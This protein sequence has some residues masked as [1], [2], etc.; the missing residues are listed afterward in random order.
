MSLAGDLVRGAGYLAVGW[1]LVRMP[2]IRVWVIAPILVGF[3]VYAGAAAYLLPLGWQW[4]QNAVAG[5]PEWFH[6]WLGFLVPLLGLVLGTLAVLLLGWL[7]VL[8]TMALASPFYGVLAARAEARLTGRRSGVERGLAHEALAAI[9]REGVKMAWYLPR[10]LLV[11]LLQM[12]PVVNLIAAPL[13]FVFAAWVL[14]IQFCDYLSENR[15]EPVAATRAALR[16]R[17]GLALGFGAVLALGLG[18]PLLN[19]LLAPA[20]V[21]GG[22]A[23]L[24]ATRAE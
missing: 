4:L 12:I 18:V 10:A 13:A 11:L 14:A 19:L 7:T 15:G 24:L 3:V 9:A 8:A 23:L 2:G 17:P 1:R 16:T 22:T 5:L 6:A 21:A 20:A